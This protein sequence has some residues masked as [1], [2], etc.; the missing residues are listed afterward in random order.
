MRPVRRSIA[1]Y[2]GYLLSIKTGTERRQRD[3]ARRI[4][5]RDWSAAGHFA[6][7]GGSDA[8]I[9]F[10]NTCVSGGRMGRVKSVVEGRGEEG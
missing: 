10:R 6:R 3:A 5:G 9:R 8:E 7:R 1:D 2:R 4:R